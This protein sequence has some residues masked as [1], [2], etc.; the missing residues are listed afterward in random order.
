M[1]I[2]FKEFLVE[3]HLMV[4][5]PKFASIHKKATTEGLPLYRGTKEGRKPSDPGDFGKG[6]YY[7]SKY[8][9]AKCYGDVKKEILKFKNPLVLTANKAYDIAQKYGTIHGKDRHKAAERMAR[10]IMRAGYDA[11]ISVTENELGRGTTELEVVDF[12]QRE[13]TRGLSSR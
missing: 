11:I 6:P 8:Y 13:R 1:N 3:K 5:D 4:S 12:R 10:G 2:G 9:R 7:T